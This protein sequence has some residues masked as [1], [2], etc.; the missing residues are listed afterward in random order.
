MNSK[1]RQFTLII[2]K[3]ILNLLREHDDKQNATR[4]A[5]M[6]IPG[7]D[8]REQAL[9]EVVTLKET[10]IFVDSVTDKSY[11]AGSISYN[12]DTNRWNWHLRPDNHHDIDT[13]EQDE[14]LLFSDALA[15]LSKEL[16]DRGDIMLMPEAWL[17]Y[18]NS[19]K[20]KDQLESQEDFYEVLKKTVTHF[21]KSAEDCENDTE[22]GED[23]FRRVYNEL[24]DICPPYITSII[25]RDIVQN[26]KIEEG[27]ADICKVSFLLASG[28]LIARLVFHINR[29]VKVENITYEAEYFQD[30]LN[31]DS[32]GEIAKYLQGEWGH[33]DI[34]HAFVQFNEWLESELISHN[35]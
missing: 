14:F 25:C 12:P 19:K 6:D 4:E 5:E 3:R 13:K 15:S 9:K 8:E 11:N 26:S 34:L 16:D 20:T 21:M 33:N 35:D 18:K 1:N 32:P 7:A 2:T 22:H 23:I 29:E 28:G 31:L 27:E 30:K 10:Q 24:T 17:E